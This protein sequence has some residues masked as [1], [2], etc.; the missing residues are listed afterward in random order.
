MMHRRYAVIC[1]LGL[2]LG[3]GVATA[4][5]SALSPSLRGTVEK[6]TSRWD[7]DL[8][9][10]DVV[11][12]TADGGQV[13][14]VEHGGSVDG[15]GMSVSHRDA[16]IRRGDQLELRGERGAYRIVSKRPGTLARTANGDGEPASPHGVQRTTRSLAPLYHATGCLSFQYDAR[17]SSK[18][19]G[20]WAAFDEAF[21]AWTNASA[22]SE[23]GGLNFTHTL[24]QDAPSGADGVNTIHFRDDSWPYSEDAVAVTRV[25]YIDDPVSPRDGEI[26]EVDIDVN[27]VGFTLAT[28]GRATAVDLTSAAAH[29]IGHALGLDHNCGVEGGAWPVDETGEL[30]PECESADPTLVAA[31]MY[32]QV[33]PG[34]TTMRTPEAYDVAGLCSVVQARCVGELSGGCSVAGAADT[35]SRGPRF[36]F[37]LPFAAL[38][39]GFFVRRR[40]RSLSPGALF[41]RA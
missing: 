12:R 4:A 29:E 39:L 21:E 5:P 13:T 31:T 18:V 40:R 9:V 38:V 2:V 36:P 34:V 19:E 22:T 35:T 3:A 32:F 25:L 7:G 6:T 23:C 24:V 11:V 41:G 30:V 15:I 17:G 10:T 14:V 33:P 27:A 26:I 8:I 1:A 28:D 16:H 20:E 37:A